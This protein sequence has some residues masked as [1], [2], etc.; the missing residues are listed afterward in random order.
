MSIQLF[1]MET[2][3]IKR[4]R[5]KSEMSFANRSENCIQ[6]IT[7]QKNTKEMGHQ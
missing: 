3:R 5:E 6:K 4:I 7:F 1:G 2:Q